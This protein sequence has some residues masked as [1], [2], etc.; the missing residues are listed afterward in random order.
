MKLKLLIALL[1]LLF[2]GEGTYAQGWI[3]SGKLRRGEVYSFYFGSSGLYAA[4]GSDGLFT[5]YDNGTTWHG[6]N[7]GLAGHTVK[8]VTVNNNSSA[9]AGTA[10]AGIYLSK[11]GG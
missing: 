11:D 1:C 6:V 9:F 7:N 5:S 4:A 8:S 2:F 3:A 10:D